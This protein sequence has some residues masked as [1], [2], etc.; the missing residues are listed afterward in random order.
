MVQLPKLLL[1][2]S[3]SEQSRKTLGQILRRSRHMLWHGVK[4][5]YALLNIALA[6]PLGY[7][8]AD[9]WLSACYLCNQQLIFAANFGNL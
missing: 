4:S 1:D 7:C 2:S 8:G 5:L 6:K 9:D 3:L